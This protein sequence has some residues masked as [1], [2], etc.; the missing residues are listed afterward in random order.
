MK[1]THIVVFVVALAVLGY[2]LAPVVKHTTS[3]PALYFTT[4]DGMIT[5]IHMSTDEVK[6]LTSGRATQ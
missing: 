6:L 3:S 1:K 5:H 2:W 4:E